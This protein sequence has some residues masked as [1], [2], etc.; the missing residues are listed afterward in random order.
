MKRIHGDVRA[1]GSGLVHAGSDS[2]VRAPSRLRGAKRM[3]LSRHALLVL[4]PSL[5][6]PERINFPGPYLL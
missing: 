3:S 4:P 6:G 5:V 1:D 2:S